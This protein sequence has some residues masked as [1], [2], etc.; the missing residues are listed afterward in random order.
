MAEILLVEDEANARRILSITLEGRGHM[1]EACASPAEA[2]ARMQQRQF[3]IVLTDLRMEG[4]DAGLEVIRLAGDLQ[5][6]ARTILLTAYASAETAVEAMKGGAFDY[7]T[8]PVSGEEL[9]LAVERALAHRR[10]DPG[11]SEEQSGGPE[12]NGEEEG[13]L[14]G[15]SAPMCRLR[16]RLL[17]A[18]GRDFTVLITGE[19][20]T[21]KE[22]AARYVHDHSGRRNKPF[23]PVHCGAIPADLFESELFGH[24]R[25]AFTGAESDRTGLIESAHEGTLF[26]DEIGEMPLSVQV[27]LLRVLQDKRVRRVGEE[28]ERQVD[29]R[30][31]AATN[32]NLEEEVRL[33]RFRED[34]FY[35]LNVVPVQMPPLRQ[36]REDIPQLVRGMMQRWNETRVRI[37]D[38][39]MQRITQLPLPGNVRELEN[40]VQRL[41]AL[42]DGD[43]LDAALLDELI[44][45]SPPAAASKGEECGSLAMVEASGLNIDDWL[46][47]VERRLITETLAAEGGSITRCAERLGVSFRSMRYR[48]EK[49]GIKEER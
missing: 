48:L 12:I 38:D 45:I 42:S 14:I 24:R 17:R 35:R 34:L 22:V 4:R 31:L 27:K 41:L 36:R 10:D 39:C 16:D 29:V 49:L 7:L 20:G 43:R 25:G 15:S 5:P 40:I 21:G 19:S 23:V 3:D 47:L 33:G 32:R 44:E 6:G 11:S 46:A 2:Q 30:L 13:S 8:K 18:A 37:S 1:V 26:L 28:R 9:A